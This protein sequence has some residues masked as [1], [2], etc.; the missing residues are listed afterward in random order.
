MRTHCFTAGRLCLYVLCL[1]SL[2]YLLPG[3][4]HAQLV[5][6]PQAKRDA[7]MQQCR[8]IGLMMISYAMDNAANNNAYPDGKS[9]TEVFQKLL[10]SGYCTD[11]S[12]FY[13]SLPGKTPAK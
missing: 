6:I 4:A 5:G 11:P 1:A 13:L 7:M 9:S 3:A 10:D 12:I 2:L 8:Q